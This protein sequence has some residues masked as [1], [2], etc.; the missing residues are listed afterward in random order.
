MTVKSSGKKMNGKISEI[1]PSSQFTGGQFQIKVTVPATES[2]DL[3]SG[4]Y[5]N[6]SIPLKNAS[7]VQSLFIPASAIIHKDQLS[8]LYTISEDHTAQ[9]RWLKVGKEYGS[10]IEILS[11][12]NPGEQFITQSDGKLYGG[13][14][15]S[16]KENHSITIR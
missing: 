13:A 8:G 11:G 5:V 14:P 4:M 3:F 10:E 15:V 7:H 16:V 9:L 2:A 1:S 12:L 6:V